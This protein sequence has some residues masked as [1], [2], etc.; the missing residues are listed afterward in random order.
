MAT[1]VLC[2]QIRLRAFE[3]LVA[4]R[5]SSELFDSFELD[6]CELVIRENIALDCAADRHDFLALFGKVMSFYYTL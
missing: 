5:G 4:S 1:S 3:C 2:F 6:A